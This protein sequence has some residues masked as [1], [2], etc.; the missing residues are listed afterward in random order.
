MGRALWCAS[1]VVVSGIGV[2]LWAADR[3]TPPRVQL[4]PRRFASLAARPGVLPGATVQR[5][6]QHVQPLA[7]PTPTFS[8]E[9]L[10]EQEAAETYDAGAETYDAGAEPLAAATASI[11]DP[12]LSRAEDDATSDRRRVP[13]ATLT[14]QPENETLAE[15]EVAEE[16][17]QPRSV[18]LIAFRAWQQPGLCAESED[19]SEAHRRLM[20]RFR[21]VGLDGQ[22][23]IYVDPRLPEGAHLPLL[24]HS[25]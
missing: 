2:A 11:P 18:E 17:A 8:E 19:S 25:L 5:S 10:I 6:A 13:P 16:H 9:P 22:A 12:D 7:E 20:T 21:A 3:S 14:A 4:A 24:P 1:L 15:E 23:H